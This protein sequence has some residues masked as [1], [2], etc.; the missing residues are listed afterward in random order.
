MVTVFHSP[1]PKALVHPPATIQ[2]LGRATSYIVVNF[3]PSRVSGKHN[4]GTGSLGSRITAPVFPAILIALLKLLYT[5]FVQA[6]H[7]KGT[8]PCP[9][10]SNIMHHCWLHP[11]L[12]TDMTSAS[13]WSFSRSQHFVGFCPEYF[14][15]YLLH[16]KHQGQILQHWHLQ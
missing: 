14:H 11:P 5:L 8:R 4:F 9:H 15:R 7:R 2:H 12:P 16:E 1:D 13:P 6:H 10:S 3:L